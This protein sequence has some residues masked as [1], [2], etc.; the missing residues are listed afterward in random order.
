MA[1]E[2]EVK[3]WGNSFGVILPKS[4]IEEYGLKEKDKIVINVVQKADLSKVFG[5][6]KKKISG[7]EFKELIKT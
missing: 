2:V 6:V 7:G 4:L 1:I 5:I 3:K